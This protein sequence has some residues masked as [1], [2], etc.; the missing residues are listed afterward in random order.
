MAAADPQNTT[1][2]VQPES[3]KSDPPGLVLDGAGAVARRRWIYPREVSGRW[4]RLRNGIFYGALLP[5]LFLLPWIRI[6]G[7][8]S[9]LMDIPARRLALFGHLFYPQDTFFLFLI[10]VFLGLSLF[11]FTSLFGRLWCGMACPQTVFIE[12]VYRPVERW[13]EGP[14]RERR[15]RDAGPRNFDYWWRKGLKHLLFFA[16]AQAIALTFVAYFHGSE[17]LV[18]DVLG[19]K[20]GHPAFWIT[21]GVSL[22]VWFDFAIFREQFCMFLCPYAR[23]QG[24]LMDDLSMVVG[25][26]Q[27]RGETR[28]KLGK[29]HGDCI[30]CKACV[31]VCP[32]GID[33][34]DGNQ[35]ECISCARCIDA[36]DAM[37]VKIGKP[38]GLVRFDTERRL[39]RGEKTGV[40]RPRPV[41]YG[42]LLAVV[43]TSF[44]VAV[45]RRPLVDL[46][47]LRQEGLAL[48][49]ADGR[50][51]NPIQ[52]KI[53]N[54]D[55]RSHRYGFD[56]AEDA[57]ELVLAG[58]PVELAPGERAELRGMLVV[59]GDQVDQV[60][61][62]TLRAFSRSERKI[63]SEH[64][65]RFLR[66]GAGP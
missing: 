25:Y 31:A 8:Q 22:V 65:L 59:A 47:V 35:L 37:M 19:F 36:C 28:G 42:V 66:P 51:A 54:K 16:I 64:S 53:M 38:T 26:D 17:R 34:R 39:L 33:I 62:L 46:V 27:G 18:D 21:L 14:V 4:T 45:A 52:V 58:L 43:L 15:R 63:R 40:L 57:A 41:I 56:L 10:L 55:G 32:T 50:V 44:G 2:S 11:F 61:R 24:V 60:E 1:P 9:V 49:L 13:I 7:Q 23:F 29:T 20:V 12:A 3:V 30:D 6:G 48:T 5:L